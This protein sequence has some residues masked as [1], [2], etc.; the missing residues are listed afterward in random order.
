LTETPVYVLTSRRTYSAAEEFTFDLKHLERA[1]VVGDTTGGG[2]HT[3]AGYDFGFDGF[4]IAIRVPHGRAFDPK[5]G[6]GWEGK[7]VIPDR[8]VPSDEALTTAHAAALR[9]R[10]EAEQDEDA[11]HRLTW[12]LAGLESELDPVTLAPD[13]LAAYAGRYGPRRVTLEDGTLW[14]QREDR[15]RYRLEPMGD[16]LF[17]VVG[18]DYFRVGFTRDGDGRVTK[19]VG[20]YDDGHQDENP[21]DGG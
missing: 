11:R 2:G 8:P 15:P 9:S 19:I 17:R 16:D 10:L 1:T 13:V 7:G 20:H 5:T 21:R 18:L 4:R 14:Y 3:V 6:E 12:A